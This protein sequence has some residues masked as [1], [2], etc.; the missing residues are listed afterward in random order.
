MSK[1]VG[2][3]GLGTM[4]KPMALHLV[5]AG[6]QVTVW[7]RTKAKSEELARQGARVAGSLREL[8]GL[9]EVVVTMV[10]DETALEAVA[11]GE[12]GLLAGLSRGSILIDM[13]TL[14]PEAS[15]RVAGAV[16]ERGAIMLRAPVGGSRPQAE[17][18]KLLIY[19]SGDKEAYEQSQDVLSAFGDKIFYVGSAEEAR[20]L[21]LAF[22]MVVSTTSHILA[23]AV[24]FAQRSGL[25]WDTIYKMFNSAVFTS[26]FVTI[27]MNVLNDIVTKGE[28]KVAATANIIG[29]DLDLVLDISKRQETPVPVT[30]TVNQFIRMMKAT[31]RGEMDY[32]AVFLL[33][34]ELAGIKRESPPHSV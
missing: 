21:K 24:L 30:A 15:L 9:S 23:E 27:K 10:T 25:P 31:G 22:N 5:R 17:A 28:H 19:V 11:F 2:F 4:G 6:F 20:Y 34:E 7:N 8:A 16:E 13:S 32:S 3:I 18:G 12:E 14:N 33:L 26:P 1:R 29:K